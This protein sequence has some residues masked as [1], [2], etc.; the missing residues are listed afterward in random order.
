[1]YIFVNGVLSD[2]IKILLLGNKLPGRRN[3]I[4]TLVTET[5]TTDTFKS[6]GNSEKS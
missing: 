2:S 4:I 3:L 1:M 5:S 6:T